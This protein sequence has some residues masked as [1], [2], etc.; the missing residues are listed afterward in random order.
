VR[1]L[2][3]ANLPPHLARLLRER[4]HEASH[5]GEIGL[6]IAGDR[7]ILQ[8]ARERGW[9][10]VTFD[11]DFAELAAAGTGLPAGIILLRLR[12]ARLDKV[13]RRLLITLAAAGDA[14]Q[15]GAVVVVEEARLRIRHP[16]P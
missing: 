12:S 10:V 4:G 16:I 1:R 8:H 7:E 6:G 3:D 13:L 14:L 2:V 5:V 15:A 9:V 11:L